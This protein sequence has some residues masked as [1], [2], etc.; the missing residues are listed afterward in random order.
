MSVKDYFV[1][2]PTVAQAPNLLV[3]H[4]CV[5]LCH[6]GPVDDPTITN[7]K[8]KTEAKEDSIN[9]NLNA[10]IHPE[11]IP[12]ILQ[13]DKNA[14]QLNNIAPD[15]LASIKRLK[16]SSDSWFTYIDFI[17]KSPQGKEKVF[18]NKDEI[19]AE[20]KLNFGTNF[21]ISGETFIPLD[22]GKRLYLD[23]SLREE[24]TAT[25][26]IGI[27]VI[28]P[29]NI[30]PIEFSLLECLELHM[31]LFGKLQNNLNNLN[32]LLS[33]KKCEETIGVIFK[34]IFN[35]VVNE[36]QEKCKNIEL[37]LLKRD[38][39]KEPAKVD[40][41]KTMYIH[42]FLNDTIIKSEDIFENINLSEANLLAVSTDEINQRQ[43]RK[44]NVVFYNNENNDLESENIIKDYVITR[45]SSA[46]LDYKFETNTFFEL[47]T[48]ESNYIKQSEVEYNVPEMMNVDELIY[49]SEPEYKKLYSTTV[50]N[51][52]LNEAGNGRDV[53]TV[54]N[55]GFDV[56]THN[57]EDSKYEGSA[58]K[59][60]EEFSTSNNNTDYV[61][62]ANSSV[63]VYEAMHNEEEIHVYKQV[64]AAS[65]NKPFLHFLII[66]SNA[67]IAK[68][69][70]TS[71]SNLFWVF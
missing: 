52:I 49:I 63:P 9:N 43:R 48:S 65:N 23:I 22:E 34:E 55:P 61:M 42:P 36:Y 4:Y 24:Q 7:K 71:T 35:N 40:S 62:P 31:L 1:L 14:A 66:L 44:D 29:E 32:V 50:K 15:S 6:E 54:I 39:P 47:S 10:Y 70:K 30:P 56:Q 13:S 57:E 69:M 26:D 16:R 17:S 38:D 68:I 51:Q 21:N 58:E 20:Q 64:N 45:S 59:G 12:E 28:I 37:V 2:T 67:V 41:D 11:H 18:D 33:N 53:N 60:F 5:S 46:L 8:L 19:K 25:D 27:H 3:D